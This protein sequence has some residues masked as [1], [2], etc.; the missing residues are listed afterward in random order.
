[1]QKYFNNIESVDSFSLALDY[2]K[3]NLECVHCKKNDQFVSHGFIYKQ[4][5]MKVSEPVGKRIICSNR[6]GRS[7]CGRTFQLYVAGEFPSLQYGTAHL[8]IFISSLLA[9]LTVS[10]S[11]QKA[12]GQQ[13]SRNAWRWLNKLMNKLIDYRSFLKTCTQ[14]LSTR[15]STR[16]RRLQI[17]L[18]T[19]T[20][21]IALTDNCPCS[22]YQQLRQRA[23][24]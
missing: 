22:H 12:T 11:Y 9:N 21:L 14:T 6:Y 19:L 7:G 13:G 15:F 18:P 10:Q 4:R 20:R 5:S 17:L 3:D 24:I 2:H 8:F 16:A 1:M 23:F